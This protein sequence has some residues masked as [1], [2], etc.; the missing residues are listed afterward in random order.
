MC[1]TW[2]CRWK[3]GG[4]TVVEN[5]VDVHSFAKAHFSSRLHVGGTRQIRAPRKCSVIMHQGL[6]RGPYHDGAIDPA[7]VSS[8]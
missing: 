1:T 8:P 6:A 2:R 7:A 3:Q 4:H 5:N